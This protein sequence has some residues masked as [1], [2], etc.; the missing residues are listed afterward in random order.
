MIGYAYCTVTVGESPE[1]VHCVLRNG[2]GAEDNGALERSCIGGYKLAVVSM[3][4]Y[5]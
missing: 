3:G 2:L 1:V 5:V 4:K